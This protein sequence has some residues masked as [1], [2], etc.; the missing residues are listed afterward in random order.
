MP[1]QNL[2]DRTLKSLKPDKNKTYDLMDSIVPGLGVRVLDSG[3]RT[4]VLVTRYPG[5]NNPTR[6]AL[7]EYGELTLE[8]ARDK[9]RGW[10]ELIRKGVDPKEHEERQRLAEQRKRANSFAAIAEKFIT[11]IHR[12]K[13]RTADAMER[14]LRATFIKRW[15]SRPITEITS[16]DVGRVIHEAVD[17][18]STYQ[19]FHDFALIR[20]MFNWAIGTDEYGLET[21]P[22]DRLNTK[23]AIGERYSR[24]RVLSDDELRALWRATDRLPYPYGALYRMLAWTGLRLGE[25][26]GAHWSEFD[27]ERREWTI[28][29]E[30]MKKV[31]GGAK[32]FMVPL[33]DAMVKVLESLPRFTSGDFLFSHNSGK[34]P[35]RPD[36]F[37]DPKERLDRI[38]LEELR[39]L[40]GKAG[41]DPKRVTLPDFVNHDIRRTVRTHLSALKIGEEVREA[42][43]AHVRPG[44]KGTYDKHQYL[45]EKREALTLWNARLRSIV[46]PPP[47]NVVD[48][49]K[50]R[51]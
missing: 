8:K 31:K 26:C 27:L 25:V 46:K 2:T 19:A 38:M 50:A 9:A 51:A 6:R 45:D 32:P 39:K 49:A 35:L 33:T 15:A 30:R 20:R 23:D 14:N 36:L 13:L 41:K 7:G 4:F 17:R 42:V 47:A 48:L 43:L 34:V 12:Q 3:R 11:Y 29:A 28:P 44:I 5:S 40:A 24:N 1:K 18:G 21:N 10:L 37:S 22:C 16:H